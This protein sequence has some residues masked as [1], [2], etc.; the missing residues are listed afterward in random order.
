MTLRWRVAFLALAVLGVAQ[1][2]LTALAYQVV[3]ATL[4][5]DA[6]ER[7]AARAV[8]ICTL[9]AHEDFEAATTPGAGSPSGGAGPRVGVSTYP[10]SGAWQLFDREGRPMEEKGRM[11]GA[12]PAWGL[13]A[14]VT[15]ADG[16]FMIIY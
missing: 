7:A 2:A 3:R 13:A 1:M 16:R 14:A 6:R 5:N 9:L 8:Q 11:E 15:S 10:R 4:W 12:V